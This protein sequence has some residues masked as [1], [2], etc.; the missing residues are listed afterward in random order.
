ML[1]TIRITPE[2]LNPKIPERPLQLTLTRGAHSYLEVHGAHG[3]FCL[4][5][6]RRAMKALTRR[7]PSYED[8]KLGSK[9]PILGYKPLRT[10][11]SII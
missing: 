11:L 4:E 9:D 1:E 5:V 6:L 8:P 3:Q 2:P 10:L 7:G